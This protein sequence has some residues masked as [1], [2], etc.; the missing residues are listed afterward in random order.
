MCL[1]AVLLAVIMLT[2]AAPVIESDAGMDVGISVGEKG[3]RR[4]FLAVGDHY[5]VPQG[6]VI[7][8]RRTRFQSG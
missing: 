1:M 8:I 5:R 4:F 6:N 3:L 2:I 7:I